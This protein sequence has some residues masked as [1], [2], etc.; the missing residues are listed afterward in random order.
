MSES[1]S[2]VKTNTDLIDFEIGYLQDKLQNIKSRINTLEKI[3]SKQNSDHD[4]YIYLRSPAS[5]E[6]CEDNDGIPECIFKIS[7]KEWIKIGKD[8]HKDESNFKSVEVDYS[9]GSLKIYE[10]ACIYI[11]FSERWAWMYF[12]F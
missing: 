1:I 6:N 2:C 5:E 4:D 12:N 8:L 7:K 11:Y 10:N 3:R 9:N